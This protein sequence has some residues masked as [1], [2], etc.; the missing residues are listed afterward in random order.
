MNRYQGMKQ[1]HK[2]KD[3]CNYL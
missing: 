1:A 3:Y 2:P